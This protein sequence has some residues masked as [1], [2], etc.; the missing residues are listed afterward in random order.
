MI[1]LRGGVTKPELILGR[2]NESADHTAIVSWYPVVQDIQP[3]RITALIW[4]ATKITVVL[5]EHER[6]IVL[7]ISERRVVNCLTD[8]ERA[9]LVHISARIV[10]VKYRLAL[11]G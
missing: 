9:T 1:V 2:G 4:I 11:A 6:W 10:P 3:E 7:S 5:H 8:G